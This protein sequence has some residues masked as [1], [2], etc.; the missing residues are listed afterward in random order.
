MA[1][2]SV[3]QAIPIAMKCR[4]CG[5][6][7]LFLVLLA[8]FPIV[9]RA[10][11]LDP[12]SLRCT[13][14][15]PAG[16]VT[17]GWVIPP[18]PTGEFLEYRIFRSTLSTGPYGL[19]ATLN[20]A[21]QTAYVDAAAGAD[22]GARYYYLTTVSTSAA[23]NTSIPSDTLAT[24]FLQVTQSVPLGSAVLD[25]NLQHTPPLGTSGAYSTIDLEHPLGTWT[26]HDS[27]VNAVRHWSQVISICD[28]SLN[29]RVHQSDASGCV[30]QS[31]STG[32]AFQDITP[33]SIPVVVNVTVDTATDQ[34]TVNW[35]PSPELDTHGYIIVF[36]MPGGNSII[37]TVYGR[38]N[39]TY[40]WP[41]SDAGLGPESYTIAAI[42]TCLKGDPPSP[43]TSATLPAHTTIFLATAY[44]RCAGSIRVTRTPYV[45][46]PVDHYEMYGSTDGPPMVPIATL[47]TLTAFVDRPNV[48]AGHSYCYVLKAIGLQPGQVSLSNKACRMTVYPP[49]PQWNYVR[50][51]TLTDADHILVVDSVDVDAY[52]RRLALERS[53]NGGPWE[54]VATMPGGTGPVVSFTDA[55]VNTA[56]RSYSY[57]VAVE[58]S[59]GERVVVSNIGTSILLTVSA[60][61][62][63]FNRL[64]WNGYEQWAGSVAGYTVFRSIADGPF[65]AIGNSP[66]DIWQFAD[67]VGGLYET[68]GK[69][70]YYVVAD[71]TGNPSGMDA[72][73][74]SNIACAVQQEEIWVPNAF[75][76]S[77]HNNT[78]I[79]VLAYAEVDRY[80]F[81]IFNRWGQQI[82]TTSDR[83][84][85][86]DGRVDGSTVP[87]GV[88]A[89][90]CS[91]VNGAGK[92]V[93][94]RGT[95]TFLPGT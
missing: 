62:D 55:D 22:T 70:C 75:I 50:T 47:D 23:P 89:W 67:N 10:T 57:R 69:F 35:D 28:D 54:E 16:G 71:E 46:W 53:Y 6:R 59:C 21:G 33:P 92:T 27:V 90:Y 36:A 39:T 78:F 20:T 8:A 51:A 13:S 72:S 9:A 74:V 42:D 11:V 29:F 2:S 73:S 60:D 5:V 63:G 66:A 48:Q 38:L 82:W 40:V 58:D 52:T 3:I 15:G 37:D 61:L 17:L 45:G 41:L 81:T 19:V 94:R 88:Y 77:G 26:L 7:D 1:C 31:N 4:L 68:P 56:D 14:V 91:F 44:D 43:N 83:Y 87:Q 18:D 24:I 93:E 80:E 65:E 30:S 76:E 12:P 84:R 25:W 64:R 95:V 49:V 34:T 32:A 79:P 85:A 86:W